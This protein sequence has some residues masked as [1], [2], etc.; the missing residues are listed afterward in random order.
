MLFLLVAALWPKLSCELS[1]NEQ[2]RS[3]LRRRFYLWN[4]RRTHAPGYYGGR[5][6]ESY[7]RF[8]ERWSKNGRD[9]DPPSPEDDKAA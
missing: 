5:V 2:D 6:R 9:T 7:D 4:R 1:D 3:S 8:L